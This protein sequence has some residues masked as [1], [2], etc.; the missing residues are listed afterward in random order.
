[1]SRNRR[2]ALVLSTLWMAAVAAFVLVEYVQIQ[3]GQCRF[4]VEDRS[5]VVALD[6]YFLSCSMFSGLVP[7][8]QA[9]WWGVATFYLADQII[10][11]SVFR[12]FFISITPVAGIWFL[13]VLVP[14]LWRWIVEREDG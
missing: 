7:V 12:L 2:A 14:A 4:D 6:G 3:P 10:E 11:L 8:G 5:T 1:M 13:I 9:P